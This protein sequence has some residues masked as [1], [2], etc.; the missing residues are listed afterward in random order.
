LISTSPFV[1]LALLQGK[2][3]EKKPRPLQL[4][5]FFAALGVMIWL[6]PSVWRD[7]EP[8]VAWLGA[9]HGEIARVIPG[10]RPAFPLDDVGF[11]IAEMVLSCLALIPCWL[12]LKRR[13]IDA[14]DLVLIALSAVT[15]LLT[16]FTRAAMPLFVV[17]LALSIGAT[18]DAVTADAGDRA[19]FRAFAAAGGF[20]LLLSLACVPRLVEARDPALREER[21][22][23]V[24][25]LRWMRA[26]TDSGGAWNAPRAPSE[27]GVLSTI[28]DGPLVQYHARRPALASPA[29]ALAS[30]ENLRECSRAFFA[31][32]GARLA[33]FMQGQR[34][35][36]AVV[37]PRLARR[38]RELAWSP[39]ETPFDALAFEREN[40]DEDRNPALTRVYASTRRVG[41]DGRA[42]RAGEPAGRVVSIYRLNEPLSTPP[43]AELRPR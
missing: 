10:L 8:A 33:R 30:I 20:V 13:P 27:W 6:L 34:A 21:I 26:G 37:G 1:V 19:R 23:F 29:G 2:S 43:R 4:V 28:A 40:A 7:V 5:C 15:F 17:A 36:Y 35:Q 11:E 39:G 42:P 22:A 9:H 24:A 3:A 18:L 38:A 31:S 14:A 41:T 25:G 16:A 32:D 12:V